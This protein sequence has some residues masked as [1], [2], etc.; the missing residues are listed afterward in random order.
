MVT[1]VEAFGIIVAVH[2]LQVPGRQEVIEAFGL[3]ADVQCI[4]VTVAMLIPEDVY[5]AEFSDAYEDIAFGLDPAVANPCASIGAPGNECPVAELGR[6]S[7]VPSTSSVPRSE[8]RTNNMTIY[9]L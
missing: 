5:Q 3:P 7:R 6:T 2:R 4:N 9:Y 1:A 8:F